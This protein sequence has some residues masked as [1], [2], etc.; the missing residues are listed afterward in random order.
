MG[1]CNN[2]TCVDQINSY[3]CICKDGFEG[4]R[5]NINIDDCA[6]QP[7][8]NNASC[9]DGVKDYTCDCK[10]GWSGKVCSENINDCVVNCAEDSADACTKSPC[11]N[12]SCIDLINDFT[13]SCFPGFKGLL[14]FFSRIFLLFHFKLI[15]FFFFYFKYCEHALFVTYSLLFALPNH[16]YQD[17]FLH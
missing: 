9:I 15:F 16:H 2:G 4:V 17:F 11:K 13:C 7:C 8:L 1:T 12:G 5:C 10:S 6:K 14:T 3:K